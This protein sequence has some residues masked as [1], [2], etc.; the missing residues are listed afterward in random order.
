MYMLLPGSHPYAL[1]S[2]ATRFDSFLPAFIPTNPHLT[3]SS[4]FPS[5]LLPPS[6]LQLE[7]CLRRG[8]LRS[9]RGDGLAEAGRHEFS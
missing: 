1:S 2:L 8:R 3:S 7:K 9:L 5:P 4:P 6:D